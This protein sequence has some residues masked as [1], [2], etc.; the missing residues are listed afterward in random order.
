M[1][2]RS[3]CDD[4]VGSRGFAD[5]EAE[6]SWGGS[7]GMDPQAAEPLKQTAEALEGIICPGYRFRGHSIPDVAPH[8]ALF[9]EQELAAQ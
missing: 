7:A 8:A 3:S 1:T 4:V 5:A 2:C 9:S 6:P